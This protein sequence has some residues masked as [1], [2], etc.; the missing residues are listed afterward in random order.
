M[1]N[2]SSLSIQRVDNLLIKNQVIE[3]LGCGNGYRENKL[4][5]GSSQKNGPHK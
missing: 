2:V 3:L 4:E 5:V 1:A